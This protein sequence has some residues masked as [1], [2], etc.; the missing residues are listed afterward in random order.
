MLLTQ[1]APSIEA[2]LGVGEPVGGSGL[3][4]VGRG[5]DAGEQLGGQIVRPWPCEGNRSRVR[6]DT[7]C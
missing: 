7:M 5:E 1:V 4:A 6:N 3:G 2:A